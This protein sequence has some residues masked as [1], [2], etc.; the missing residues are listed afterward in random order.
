MPCLTMAVRN[1]LLPDVAKVRTA[2]HK[3]AVKVINMNCI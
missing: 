2:A 1:N 3:A